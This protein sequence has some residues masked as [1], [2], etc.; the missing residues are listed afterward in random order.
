MRTS[1]SIHILTQTHRIIGL[2]VA[3]LFHVALYFGVLSMFAPHLAQWEK[4]SRHFTASPDAIL[5]LDSLVPP[6]L[7][8]GVWPET[9]LT[10]TL[11]GSREPALAIGHKLMTPILVNPAT[12]QTIL[13]EGPGPS[14]LFVE[15]HLGRVL[16]RPGVIVMGLACAG[17]LFLIVNGWWLCLLKSGSRVPLFRAHSASWERGHRLLAQWLFPIMLI[18][19]LTS[20]FF[21]LMFSAG[22]G[23]A[24]VASRGEA[25]QVQPVLGAAVFPRQAAVQATG[26]S[27]VMVSL[28]N[29]LAD[30]G[31]AFPDMNIQKITIDHWGDQAATATFSG[32]SR[33]RPWQTERINRILATYSLVDG[34]L[35]RHKSVDDTHIVARSLS[36]FYFLHF[37]TDAGLA[38]RL[39]MF[40]C[41]LGLCMTVGLCLLSWSAKRIR[42]APSTVSTFIQTRLLAA[43]IV[44]VLPATAAVLAA[45]WLLPTDLSDRPTWLAGVLYLTWLGSLTW[46]VA[47]TNVFHAVRD[48]LTFAGLT[49]CL[50]PVTHGLGNMFFWSTLSLGLT[51]IAAV[52]MALLLTGLA[53]CMTAWRIKANFPGE[54]T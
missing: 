4:Q 48:L 39:P 42:H 1:Q 7:D 32:P 40:A 49:F 38:V 2:T 25:A 53:L 14:A 10:I 30:A 17:A 24:W 54:R 46:C 29:L 23:L 8:E 35:L 20:A 50:L 21:G 36:T 51:T 37:M 31:Q 3:V 43:S 34:S 19:A 13:D 11:P 9:G 15:L 28:D 5:P 45:H 16:G 18:L 6:R 47:R 26:H 44:G 52:D 33:T 41:G 12:G 27:A 22:G